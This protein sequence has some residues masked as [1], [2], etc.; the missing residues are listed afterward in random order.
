MGHLSCPGMVQYQILWDWAQRIHSSWTSYSLW[1][2]PHSCSVQKSLPNLGWW[3]PHIKGIGL[4]EVGVLPLGVAVERSVHY[5]G[6]IGVHVLPLGVAV[7]LS[8]HCFRDYFS[9]FL[10]HILFSQKG[11]S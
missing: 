1:G 9:F 6:L 5:F 11:L 7:E 4:S 3:R 2:V 8:V 10:R